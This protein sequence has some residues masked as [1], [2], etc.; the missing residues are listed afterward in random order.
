MITQDQEAV[1]EQIGDFVDDFFAL[2]AFGRKQNFPS[3]LGHFF[4]NLVVT[5]LKK[6][7]RIGA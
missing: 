6:F 2:A 7:G 3:L 5:A 1:E 4:E